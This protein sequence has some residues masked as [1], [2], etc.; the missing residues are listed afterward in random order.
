MRFLP[1]GFER[2]RWQVLA[3]LLGAGGKACQEAVRESSPL[4]LK[5][6][7]CLGR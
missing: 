6:R 2:K 7:R 1:G 4:D 5:S 3:R